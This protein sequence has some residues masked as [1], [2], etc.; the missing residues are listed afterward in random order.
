MQT[1]D[2]LLLIM[3]V[4]AMCFFIIV[5][6]QI[7]IYSGT[8]RIYRS[9][10]GIQLLMGGGFLLT[11]ISEYFSSTPLVYVG[12]L[13]LLWN[14]TVPAI[15]VML[16][17]LLKGKRMKKRYVF[18][19]FVFFILF[20][21]VY[22]V[23]NNQDFLDIVKYLT[24][25]YSTIATISLQLMMMKKLKHHDVVSEKRAYMWF[26]IVMWVM[27]VA[28]LGRF[29]VSFVDYQLARLIIIPILIAVY[30]VVSFLLRHGLLDFH[31]L[32]REEVVD[33]FWGD[34]IPTT[35]P[36]DKRPTDEAETLEDEDNTP[37][38]QNEYVQE[39]LLFFGNLARQLNELMESKQ[40][41]LNPDL[42]VAALSTELGTNRTYVSNLINQF[43][44]TT[45]SAYVNAYRV[46]HAKNLLLETDDTIEDIF[47][48]SGFQS[49]TTFWRAFAQEV[50]CTPKEFRR[51]A[52]MEEME[53]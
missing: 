1:I 3:R 45:F 18:L 50:G 46:K 10:G 7:M 16:Y 5:A 40:L 32:Q 49:R 12:H 30:A 38:E 22:S 14:L 27:Y 44:R 28:L 25:T 42:T 31:S 21:L 17:E 43:L 37:T 34:V 36:A 53:E 35:I 2:L 26:V 48:A 15:V 8:S 52:M 6:L 13:N 47:Q 29:V 4:V 19:N 33:D 20:F 39:Q 9:F 41:Y 11:I 51:K 23:N 24:L